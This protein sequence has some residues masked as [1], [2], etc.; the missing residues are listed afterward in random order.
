MAQANS[1]NAAVNATLDKFFTVFTAN[2]GAAIYKNVDILIN[3]VFCADDGVHPWIG[4]A[5]H[6]PHFR[7]TAAIRTLYNQVF[8]S[9]PDIW[10]G[11]STDAPPH[12]TAPVP[13][14]PPAPRLYSNDAWR[15]PTIGVQTTMAG[16]LQ[17]PWFQGP[18]YSLPLSGLTPAV[19]PKRTNTP[20]FA[21]FAFGAH[22]PTRVSQ[23]SFYMDRYNQARELQPV[24]PLP[25]DT[26][27]RALLQHL[28]DRAET[29]RLIELNRKTQS[30]LSRLVE[31]LEEHQRNRR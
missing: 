31:T 23:I 15:P 16:T 29:Q 2:S 22:D 11:P 1:D 21:V 7:G 27:V 30:D 9:F 6:G 25:F 3:E 24:G 5:H 8:A 17:H 28:E 13:P 14:P 26:D 10:W 4:I 19:P 12:T 20:S 18:G